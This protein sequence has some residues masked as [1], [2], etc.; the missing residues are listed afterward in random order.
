MSSTWYGCVDTLHSSVLTVRIV[1][2]ALQD[3]VRDFD[4]EAAEHVLEL[5]PSPKLVRM[6][7]DCRAMRHTNT[8]TSVCG[9]L[10]APCATR[11]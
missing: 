1:G 6:L 9:T 10:L 11:R 4:F 2:L 5:P 7:S 3:P 8:N